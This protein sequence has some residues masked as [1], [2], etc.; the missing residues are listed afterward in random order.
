[1]RK[2]QPPLSQVD[3]PDR[4]GP[5]G[6]LSESGS[7]QAQFCSSLANTFCLLLLAPH[8]CFPGPPPKET[9]TLKSQAAVGEPKLRQ[10]GNVTGHP[11]GSMP[12]LG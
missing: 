2:G 5:S 11:N 3:M 1:M 9:A 10:R 6:P 7:T 4:L 8:S 12:C